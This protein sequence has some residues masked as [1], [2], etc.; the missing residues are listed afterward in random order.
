MRPDFPGGTFSTTLTWTLTLTLIPIWISIPTSTRP[1]PG[2]VGDRTHP[3]GGF[4]LIEMLITLVVIGILAAVMWLRV[5]G[6]N[7]DAYRASVKADLRSVALA[8]ELYHQ[9]NMRYGALA[10]LSA[11][12]ATEGVT[13][14][15]THVDGLGFA[16]TAAHE[17]LEPEVCGYYFGDTPAGA[18]APAEAPGVV[19]CD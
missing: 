17:A 18:G 11:Y 3:R 12:R 1:S 13:L 14:T 9:R 19:T 7:T 16:A 4:T 6:V 2:A 15:L 5:E 10:D 8:Q